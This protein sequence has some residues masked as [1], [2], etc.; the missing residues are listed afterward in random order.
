MLAVNAAYA[1]KHPVA[2]KRVIRAILK[3]ADICAGEPERVARMLVDGGRTDQYE[4]AVQAL[5]E[6]PYRSWRDYYPE[7]TVRFFSLRLH[8]AG[9]VKSNPNRI[10]SDG[11]DWRYLDEIGLELKG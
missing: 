9:I 5:R 6:L 4:Y 10:I 8:E 11:T 3:S 1:E 2:T 7:D